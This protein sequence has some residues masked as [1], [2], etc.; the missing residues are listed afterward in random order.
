MLYEAPTYHFVPSVCNNVV[1]R[2]VTMLTD[3][4][5]PNTDGIDPVHSTNIH[6]YNT[7][8]S[9]GDDCVAVKT[10][11][12][13]ILVENCTFAN[14]EGASVGTT[15]GFSHNI[16]FRNIF[17]NETTSGA[18]I[19]SQPADYGLVQNVTFQ[20][21]IMY[22]VHEPINLNQFCHGVGYVSNN[23]IANI[24]FSDIL[25][26]DTKAPTFFLNCSSN[27]PCT[28]ILFQNI[29]SVELKSLDNYTEPCVSVQ[30]VY[31]NVYPPPL[32]GTATSGVLDC[33]PAVPSNSTITITTTTLDR[34]STDKNTI[35]VI[36][37]KD[38]RERRRVVMKNV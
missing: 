2:N 3:A 15:A 8:I 21:L 26:I 19:K 20:N 12:Y 13:N 10:D 38:T 11:C 33:P 17:F 37:H 36:S 31:E 1:V 25:L 32:N 24:T 16:T 14:G 27:N 18:R 35:S 6:I 34:E 22:K 30:A 7:S 29:T 9:N 4:D 23:T 5:G 28:G